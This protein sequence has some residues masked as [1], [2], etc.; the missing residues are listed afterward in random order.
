VKRRFRLYI[1]ESGDHTYHQ[2]D[3]PEK[4]YLALIGCF[5]SFEQYPSFQEDLEN[6]KHKHF[7]YDP[8]F[9]LIL[10]RK[11]LINRRGPF[12]RLVDPQAEELFN[13]D[14]LSLLERS[15]FRIIA[16]VIDK[17]SHIERYREAAFHP[18][19]YCLASLLERYCGYLNFMNAVGDVLA[20]SRG[21]RED[22]QLKE[23]FIR[24]YNG[25]TL[26]REASFFQR[27]LTSKEIKL[28]PKTANIAGLQL[29]DLLAYPIK[30]DILV[31]EGKIFDPGD[32]FGKRICQVIDQKYNSH[33]YTARVKGYG[34]VF[35]K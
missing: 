26:W 21:G 1:D 13:Q 35:L 23:A 32:V 5:F 22:E 8:D 4:R 16:V 24:I 10:H 9:P 29:A 12:R 14:F 28:K 7:T 17:L 20:E 25:G 11:E 19:H 2:I 3:A 15:D 27:T 31:E 30:Q 33:I 6:L 18:Y 34:R